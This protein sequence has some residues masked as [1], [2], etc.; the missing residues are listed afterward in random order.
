[1]SGQVPSIA[2]VFIVLIGLATPS[3]AA[4]SSTKVGVLQCDVSAGIGM[5]LMEKQRMRCAFQP[6][7]GGL[8]EL[9]NGRIEEFGI[10]LGEVAAGHLVWGVIAPA[11]G[12]PQGALAGSYSGVGAEATLGVGLGANA[13]VGGTGRAF[14]LQPLSVEGQIGINVAAGVTSVSLVSVPR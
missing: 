13:L 8:P 14:S 1:M 12:V 2:S 10:A 9:Y 6:D 11:S 4:Q 3:L 5:I 7:R